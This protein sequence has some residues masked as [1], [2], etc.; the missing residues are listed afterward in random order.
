MLRHRFAAAFGG[1]FAHGSA[2]IKKMK[3]CPH[4]EGSDEL[5]D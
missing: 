5:I 4:R 2:K 1:S 3:K